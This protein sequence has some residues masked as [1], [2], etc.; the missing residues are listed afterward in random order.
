[1]DLDRY[2]IDPERELHLNEL[3][4][5]ET[6]NESE[7]RI[8]DELIPLSVE[9]LKEL[10]LKFHAQARH[11]IVVV[12]QALDAAGKDEIIT[13]IFSHL[14]P[15]GL[16][17][18]SMKPPSEEEQQHDF[19]W[20]VHDA[21]PA[22]GQIGILN[23][24]YYEDVLALLTGKEEGSVPTIGTVGEEDWILRCGHINQYEKYLTENGF[25]V[26]KFFPYVSP[27]VQK[28]RLLQRMKDPKRHWEFSFSDIRDREKWGEFEAAYE[29]VLNHT[30]T[31]WAPWYA[32]PADD[33]WTTRYL[34]S[35]IMIQVLQGL[36]P[37]FPVIEGEAKAQLDEDIRRLE[38]GEL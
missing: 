14:L 6:I 31:P 28:K 24:S 30:S 3:P 35:E 5:R 36:D 15:Q 12:L 19:L 18:T 17:V 26:V 11:G 8:R 10:H 21:M 22:R 25:L 9:R 2:R 33:P 38:A 32:L 20:R 4:Q 27:E 1:M 34:V 7:A 16:K 37:K 23:R 29:K 13:F